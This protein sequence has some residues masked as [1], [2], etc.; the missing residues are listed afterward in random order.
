ATEYTVGPNGPAAMPAPLPENTGYTYAVELG[1]DEVGDD[2]M[3]VFD[4]PVYLYVDH[5]LENLGFD[6]T[7]AESVPVGYYDRIQHTWVASENGRILRIVGET[8]GLA[9]IDLT[10]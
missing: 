10:G 9:D 7:Q 6:F 3:V 2:A 1:I 4:D 5:F 8:G